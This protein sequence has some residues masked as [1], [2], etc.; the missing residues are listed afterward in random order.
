MLEPLQ[1]STKPWESISL[2]LI[3]GFSKV[4][5]MTMILVMVDRFSKYVEFI[6]M[7]KFG[8]AGE[9]ARTV[10]RH[11]AKYW[12]VPKSIISDRDPRFTSFF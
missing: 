11:V 4:G 3:V 5:D 7:Q 12:G 1:M 8:S 6:T 2:D 10:F 9:M